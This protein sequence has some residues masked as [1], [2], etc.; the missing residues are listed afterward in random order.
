MILD[1]K[2]SQIINKRFL[3]IYLSKTLSV[4]L[5]HFSFSGFSSGKICMRICLGIYMSH[6]QLNAQLIAEIECEM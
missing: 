4:G 6:G 2:F 3:K 5:R 1:G